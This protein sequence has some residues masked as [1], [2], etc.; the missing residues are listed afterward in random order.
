MGAR[1]LEKIRGLHVLEKKVSPQR[2]QSPQRKNTKE[3]KKQKRVQSISV[4][5]FCF[6]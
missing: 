6:F 3:N 5:Y 2:T 1:C 4:V